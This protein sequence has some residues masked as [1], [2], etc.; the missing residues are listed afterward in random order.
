M[1]HRKHGRILSRTPAHRRAL[2]SALTR[3][4]IVRGHITT[5]V[6]KAKEVRSTVERLISL[7]R[8]NTLQRRRMILQRL[9]DRTTTN[10]LLTTIGPKYASRPG[11]YTRIVKLGTRAGDGAPLA[12]LELV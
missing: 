11:G 1:R 2:A 12:R 7:A 5:T 3:S 10:A 6:A 4:L 9:N 8:T